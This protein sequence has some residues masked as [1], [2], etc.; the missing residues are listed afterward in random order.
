MQQCDAVM[1]KL[2]EAR[3]SNDAAKMRSAIDET[4]KMCEQ[5]KGMMSQC[6]EENRKACMEMMGM[7]GRMHG[8]MM[9]HSDGG[10]SDRKKK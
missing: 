1:G 4:L 2:R 6:T 5:M 7:M 8:G 10:S 9:M 3:A